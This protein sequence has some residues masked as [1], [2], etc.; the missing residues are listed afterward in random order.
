M[1]PTTTKF[2]ILFSRF[3]NRSKYS[4]WRMFTTNSRIVRHGVPNRADWRI[5]ANFSRYLSCLES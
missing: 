2:V 1:N 3:K 5:I 4:L